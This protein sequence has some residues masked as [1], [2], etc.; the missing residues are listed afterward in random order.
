VRVCE[1]YDP[2]FLKLCG[3]YLIGE[4]IKIR[5]CYEIDDEEATKGRP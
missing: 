5:R 3:D 2:V 4:G 1:V